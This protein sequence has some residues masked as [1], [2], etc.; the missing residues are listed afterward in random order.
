M[1]SHVVRIL[2]LSLVAVV[3]FGAGAVLAQDQ[4]SPQAVV[5]S[6]KGYLDEGNTQGMLTIYGEIDEQ[7]PLKVENYEKMRPSMEHFVE[8]WQYRTFQTDSVEVNGEGAEV[9]HLSCAETN[10]LIKFY[11]R[12][13]EDKWFIADI[14]VYSLTE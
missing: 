7:I 14:E 5:A 1:N 6:F 2:A 8:S 12:L 11:T 4:S 3:W 9:I 10:E 13:Y